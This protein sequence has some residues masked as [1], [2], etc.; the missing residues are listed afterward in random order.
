MQLLGPDLDLTYLSSD[1]QELLATTIAAAGTHTRYLQTLTDEIAARIALLIEWHQRAAVLAAAVIRP[2]LD[3]PALSEPERAELSPEAL[4]LAQQF[5]EL[6]SFDAA[7]GDHSRARRGERLRHLLFVGYTNVE[8]ALLCLAAHVVRMRSIDLLDRRAARL[9]AEDN[10]AIFLPLIEM[11]GI[12]RLRHELGARGL[13]LLNPD[14]ILQ[15][16][17]KQQNA[18]RPLREQ[19][20][21]D[22]QAVLSREMVAVGMQGEIRLHSNSA[23]GL[24]QRL[25]H[26]AALGVI[27]RDLVVD[28]LVAQQQACYLLLGLIHRHWRPL[29]GRTVEGGYF[30]DLIS[31][32]KSNGYQALITTVSY[33]LHKLPEIAVQFRIRTH[34][35]EQ[36]NALGIVGTKFARRPV[37]LA[38]AWW[39]NEQRIS[40]V[41]ARPL[42][43]TSDDLYVFS[44]AGEVV[45]LPVGSTPIDY[46]YHIHSEKG[47]HCKRIWI[48]G[49]EASY[50]ATL[51][52]GDLVEIDVD[53]EYP[54]PDER[55]LRVVKTSKAKIHIKRGLKQRL[56]TPH[57]GRVWI[58]RVLARELRAY[59]LP[60]IPPEE[61]DAF[62]TRAA[63]Y[64]GYADREALY[65][66]L[67]ARKH[68]LGQSLPSPD[69]I[70]TRLIASR[71]S[72]HVVRA[73]GLPLRVAQIQFAQCVHDKK[74]CRV[75]P[76]VKIVGRVR[77]PGTEAARLT[78]YR[79]DCPNAPQ[80]EAAIPLAWR[81]DSRP[82]E[83]IK[84][85]VKAVDRARLLGD[86]L[87]TIY[88]LYEHP[89]RLYLLELAAAIDRDRS[90]RIELKV[91]A[92]SHAPIVLLD[93]QLDRLKDRG[94]INDFTISAL[95]PIEKLRLVD[96]ELL[97]NPY[98]TKAVQDRR[99]FKG[100]DD[101]IRSLI[102]RLRGAQNHIVLYGMSRVG[103]TSLLR[104][105]RD[106]IE[107]VA[108]FVPVFIDMQELGDC[109]E[110]RIW[111]EI[112]DTAEQRLS[113]KGRRVRAGRK[114]A[115]QSLQT[116]LDWWADVQ[117][118][119]QGQRLL[120]M[121]DEF[122]I[123]DEWVD[124]QRA[125]MFVHRLKHLIEQQQ[126]MA[127][128]TC[129]QE[130]LFKAAYADQ[131]VVSRPL[132]R[133]GFPLRLDYLDARAAE[134][135]IREPMG[136]LLRYDETVVHQ[137]LDLTAH[138]P[139]F[140]QHLLGRVVEHV[141]LAG[142]RVVT[143]ADLA[144][145][146]DELLR[147]GG[148]TL[149]TD[150]LREY[151]RLG[152]KQIVLR[153]LAER[154]RPGDVGAT[155]AE[156]QAMLERYQAAM[157][158]AALEEVLDSLCDL[159]IVRRERQA[160]LVRHTIRVPLFAQWLRDNRPL[161]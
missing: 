28:V 156:L 113:L 43:S 65:Y 125:Q 83:A 10:A 80:N 87:E 102:T 141:N 19:C 133:I 2:L 25:L 131:P 8:V 129:V 101:E 78:V 145:V 68:P 126:E 88:S 29:E 146:A 54:G 31:H 85:R 123:V 24:H 103:K 155:I 100:R 52:N 39:Q 116:F 132:V 154:C 139:F 149:F 77:K 55:W 138:H 26:G 20:F 82:G 158:A 33:R 21:A 49:H 71:L 57:E 136:E 84:V 47:K 110:S 11:L 7:S 95:S 61:V 90:A 121:I 70:V 6:D 104:Y 94:T 97:A 30:R 140:L 22:I 161:A 35:M 60:D 81:G 48:N 18:A 105:L 56:V 128:I 36:T 23:F 112:I 160:A 106:T 17:H 111:A 4:T 143:A 62:L 120:I 13:E 27:V 93:Q 46:A 9:L 144:Y 34:A 91:E 67:A 137:L 63:H 14:N 38:N 58:D 50:D 64:L 142:R 151:R 79:A 157:S 117:P 114:K 159:G 92:Q 37:L 127:F 51:H 147:H 152:A 73:D 42:G 148:D 76:G 99:V 72:D 3:D 74:P 75:V 53:P 59:G 12:W 115:E 15:T 40:F 32:P 118:V 109:P 5:R 98:T 107:H 66:D 86:V 45:I 89:D 130:T 135:L 134:R 44:P 124:K 16:I 1:E 122:N 69:Q 41:R 108:S 119:L 96:P 150:F 153:C